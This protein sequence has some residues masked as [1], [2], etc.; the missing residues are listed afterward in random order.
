VLDL[1]SGQEIEWSGA[2]KQGANQSRS[3]VFRGVHVL[4]Q[5]G[6]RIH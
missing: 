5:P 4:R 2:R 6:T 3:P 1:C